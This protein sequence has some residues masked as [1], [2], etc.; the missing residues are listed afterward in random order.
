MLGIPMA[1]MS[2]VARRFEATRALPAMYSIDDH[3][4]QHYVSALTPAGVQNE[5]GD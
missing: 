2:Y 3:L 5:F 1:A 4:P